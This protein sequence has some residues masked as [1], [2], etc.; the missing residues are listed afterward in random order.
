[1]NWFKRG[2]G[3][4]K[5]VQTTDLFRPHPGTL[6]LALVRPCLLDWVQ[7]KTP[8]ETPRDLDPV[9][10]S[11]YTPYGPYKYD[12]TSKL[13][14]IPVDCISETA[15]IIDA[16]IRVIYLTH[17]LNTLARSLNQDFDTFFNTAV[18]GEQIMIIA[19]VEGA[20]PPRLMYSRERDVFDVL[21]KSERSGPADPAI[22]GVITGKDS[23][24][25]SPTGIVNPL[26][27]P[28]GEYSFTYW[29]S[30]IDNKTIEKMRG[31]ENIV[32]YCH[33]KNLPILPSPERENWIAGVLKP[34]LSHIR[35]KVADT[36]QSQP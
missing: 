22:V 25:Y 13:A 9:P 16:R 14:L 17:I 30:S 20:D 23:R 27:T 33:E 15:T 11:F 18:Q 28:A 26:Q 31:L 8:R 29:A 5:D 6:A 1:M 35:L 4:P 36:Q 34:F 19:G 10:D 24:L 21:S 3:K 7:G 2:P 32:A 12:G